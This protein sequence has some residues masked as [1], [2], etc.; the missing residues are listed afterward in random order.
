MNGLSLSRRPL[1]GEG[2]DLNA[3]SMVNREC[4]AV[5]HLDEP[6]RGLDVDS[7]FGANVNAID[8]GTRQCS[9][10]VEA[11]DVRC[12]AD[13]NLRGAQSTCTPLRDIQSDDYRVLQRGGVGPRR[14]EIVI[15]EQLARDVTQ[16][17]VKRVQLDR[18]ARSIGRHNWLR[19]AMV[20]TRQ[21]SQKVQEMHE[22]VSF[23]AEYKR[24]PLVRL[25]RRVDHMRDGR[26]RCN[27]VAERV[28][29]PAEQFVMYGKPARRALAAVRG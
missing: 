13:V 1:G 7:V 8:D 19:F 3:A 29:Q 15:E 14:C 26:N 18:R 17:R 27:A 24:R 6:V 12:A 23:D 20:V 5:A 2:R 28:C 10:D 25:I 21:Q 4:T 22:M 11:H 9:H 16:R